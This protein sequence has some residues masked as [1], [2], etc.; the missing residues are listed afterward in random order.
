MERPTTCSN[1][2]QSHSPRHH[3]KLPQRRGRRKRRGAVRGMADQRADR[4]LH[5]VRKR[6]IQTNPVGNRD[7]RGSHDSVHARRNAGRGRHFYRRPKHNRGQSLPIPPRF[8]QAGARDGDLQ[9]NVVRTIRNANPGAD[10]LWAHAKIST[11]PTRRRNRRVGSVRSQSD[12]RPERA[13]RTMP[14]TTSITTYAVFIT[15]QITGI[16]HAKSTIGSN[17]S[18]IT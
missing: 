10:Q 3:G 6:S 9:G 5:R 18:R 7:I 16:S 15:G 2:T 11:V 12:A 13:L 17:T 4:I 8:P 1:N 14:I